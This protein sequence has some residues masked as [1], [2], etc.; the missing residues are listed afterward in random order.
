MNQNSE[1]INNDAYDLA[2]LIYDLYKKEKQSVIIKTE[3]KKKSSE[4]V[5]A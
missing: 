2:V 5:E 1:K 4:K 3:I